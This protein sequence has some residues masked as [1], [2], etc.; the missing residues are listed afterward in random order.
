MMETLGDCLRP[1]GVMYLP[2]GTIQAE[3]RVLA[4]ARRLFGEANMDEVVSRELPL[5]GLI[6]KS[7]A[8][9]QLVADGLVNL[10]RKGS[11]LLWRITVWRCRRS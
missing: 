7:Q 4:A 8:L 3:S 10:R 1:G 11:R 2:T 6:A 9:A 5:P